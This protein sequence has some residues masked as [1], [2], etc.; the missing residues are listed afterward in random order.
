MEAAASTPAGASL[1]REGDAL[2]LAGTLLRSDIAT[3]WRQVDGAVVAG[4]TRLDLVAVSRIDSAGLAFLAEMAARA[5]VGDLRVDGQPEGLAELTAAYR[6]SPA[7]A[8]AN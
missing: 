1:R 6:L 5:G 3:L 7:L 2:V 4:A 8:Y